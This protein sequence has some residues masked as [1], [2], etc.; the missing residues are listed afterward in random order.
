MSTSGQ[1]HIILFGGKSAVP[2]ILRQL[3]WL[4]PHGSKK[5]W[6]RVTLLLKGGKKDGISALWSCHCRI[7]G[8]R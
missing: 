8:L 5:E 6:Y 1:L 7:L 2:D 4:I 3:N